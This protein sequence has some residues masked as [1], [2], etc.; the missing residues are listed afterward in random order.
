MGTTSLKTLLPFC[1]NS[2]SGELGLESSGEFKNPKLFLILLENLVCSFVP[3]TL[4]D[5]LEPVS[6]S[7]T[8][9]VHASPKIK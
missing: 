3:R 5:P 8:I 9:A 1:I 4:N 7:H 6:F 2:L